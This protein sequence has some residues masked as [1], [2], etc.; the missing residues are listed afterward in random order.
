MRY[1]GVGYAGPTRV[2][3]GVAPLVVN[4]HQHDL[5]RRVLVFDKVDRMETVDDVAAE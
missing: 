4:K 5:I 3:G 1:E 2:V